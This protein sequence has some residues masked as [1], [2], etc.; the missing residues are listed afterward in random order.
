MIP[1]A[2]NSPLLTGD[3]HLLHAARTQAR[4]GFDAMRSLK[5]DSPEVAKGVA[6]AE[7]V[8]KLL[9]HNIVQGQRVEGKDAIRE[10]PCDALGGGLRRWDG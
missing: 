1:Q 7:E 3:F 4:E 2:Q 10:S 6:H 5:S 8:A 9:R